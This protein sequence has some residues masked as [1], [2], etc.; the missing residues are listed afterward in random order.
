MKP[1]SLN[2]LLRWIAVPVVFVV[3]SILT[4]NVVEFINKY[5]L[6]DGIMGITIFGVIVRDLFNQ[7]IVMVLSCFAT[8]WAVTKTIPRRKKEVASFII[9][10][11]GSIMVFHALTVAVEIYNEE[12]L[13]FKLTMWLLLVATTPLISIGAMIYGLILGLKE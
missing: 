10:L 6:D 13:T 1:F 8:L 3:V 12:S 4:Y 5:V 2:E 9:F 11:W 7:Y